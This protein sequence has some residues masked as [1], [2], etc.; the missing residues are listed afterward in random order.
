MANPQADNKQLRRRWHNPGRRAVEEALENFAA[1]CL[2]MEADSLPKGHTDP[3]RLKLYAA[4]ERLKQAIRNSDVPN[5]LLEIGSNLMG[6]EQM[7]LVAMQ[8]NSAISLLTSF[9]LSQSQQETLISNSDRI[10][11]AIKCGKIA[12]ADTDSDHNQ[13]WLELGIT[14][15]VPVWYRGRPSGAILFYKLLPQRDSFDSSDRKLLQMLSIFSG[16]SLFKPEVAGR[17][18]TY[19]S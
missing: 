8:K 14:A 13:L 15:F 1:G 6:C 4:S 2:S 17:D 7:A 5:A 10:A 3:L 12:V 16:P 18:A 19:E 9:G 11:A